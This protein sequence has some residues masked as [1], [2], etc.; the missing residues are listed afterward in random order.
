[1][2]LDFVIP[3]DTLSVVTKAFNPVRG[4]G[5]N[6]VVVAAA[7]LTKLV[8]NNGRSPDLQLWR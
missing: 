2:R 7:E 1:M 3:W 4:T 8:P 5:Q 6:N